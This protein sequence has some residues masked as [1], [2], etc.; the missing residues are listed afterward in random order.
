[1][2]AGTL[3]ALRSS[4]MLAAG[5]GVRIVLAPA[6][7]ALV[8]SGSYTAA[9]V[10]FVIAAVTDWFDGRLARRW[11]VTTRLGAFLDTTADKLLVTT[12]LVALVAVDR[13]SPWVALV[14]IGR[15]FTILGLRAAVASGGRPPRDLDA[16]QVEGHDPVRGD[17]FGHAAPRRHY[18]RRLPGRVG[19]GVRRAGHRL[20]GHR[21]P[22]ALLRLAAYLAVS[23]V[24]VT[25]GGGVVGAALVERLVARGDEVIGLARSDASAAAISARGAQVVRGDVLDED[26]LAR[27]MEACALAFH[28]A[29]VNEMCVDDT[30][31]MRRVNVDGAVN[32][33]RAAQRAGVP[34][35]VHTSSAAT[36]GEPPGTVGSEATPH[37]GWYLSVYEQTKTEA[38]ARCSPSRAR[39]ARTSCASTRRRSRGP[40]APA[41]RPASCS[42]F[43]TGA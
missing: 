26:A 18:R 16:R 19:H 13:A 24:F 15:E 4:R 40:V 33:V 5:T 10:V 35:L 28:V 32:A 36:I 22:P 12:A 38:S 14:I 9:A 30:G 43:S 1:V 39:P 41:A 27:G 29:G 23:R 2:E 34:R 17:H 20:V 31:Y 6:V 8:L 25:G 37:R 21:L 11:G 7:M 42:P 3:S